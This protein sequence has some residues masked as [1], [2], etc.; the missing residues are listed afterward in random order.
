[1]ISCIHWYRSIHTCKKA[2]NILKTPVTTVQ[3]SELLFT[4][5]ICKKWQTFTSRDNH[6]SVNHG[7]SNEEFKNRLNMALVLFQIF[8]Y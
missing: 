1:M 8:M 4:K 2:Q 7:W 3:W 5:F 6:V